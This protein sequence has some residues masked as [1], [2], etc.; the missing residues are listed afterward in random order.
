MPIAFV[1]SAVGVGTGA[2]YTVNLNGTLTGGLASSPATGDIVLVFTAFGHTANVAPTVSG[3]NSGAYTAATANIYGND[4]WDTNFRPLYAVQGAAVDNLLTITRQ[5]T[6]TYGGAT[7][8]MVWRG[9]DADNPI[10]VTP[11]TA[12]QN[13]PNSCL[14][15]APAITPVTEGAVIIAAGAGTMPATSVDFTGISGMDNFRTV[16]GDGS[17]SDTATAAASIFWSGSGSYDPAAVA[18]GTVNASS[19]WSA[20]SLVLRPAPLPAHDLTASELTAGSPVLGS[21]ALGQTHGLAATELLAGAPALGAPS[22]GQVQVLAATGISA[23]APVLGSPLLE[24]SSGHSLTATGITAGAPILGSPG[25]GQTHLLSATGVT[26]GAPALAAPALGQRHAL[27]ASALASGLPVLG[28]TALG[29]THVLAASGV[30]LGSPVLGAPP[31]SQEVVHFLDAV[32]LVTGS[33]VLGVPALGQVHNLAAAGLVAGVPV[34]GAPSLGQRHALTALEILAGSPDLGFASLGQAHVLLAL[35]FATDPAELGA[36]AL[37]LG[38]PIAEEDIRGFVVSRPRL[39]LVRAP[40]R[41]TVSL[42][43]NRKRTVTYA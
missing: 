37:T 36:P 12:A 9:V 8:V 21:P 19:S 17:T 34:L 32:P 27:T 7:V 24:S 41:E 26:A 35:G 18:G 22:L 4:T 23:G 31:L 5:N 38:S 33:P 10:D 1:G 25:L 14:F 28:S 2:S 6:T 11:T 39:V 16:K 43:P 20:A 3:N 29:Q 30:T 42:A 40:G 15:N 13:N